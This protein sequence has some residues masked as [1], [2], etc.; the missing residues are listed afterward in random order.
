MPCSGIPV[1]TETVAGSL[2]CTV[3]V[4]MTSPVS[5]LYCYGSQQHE[6][7][8]KHCLLKCGYDK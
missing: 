4:L 1:K 3:C 5:S 8:L 6:V 7:S 2:S